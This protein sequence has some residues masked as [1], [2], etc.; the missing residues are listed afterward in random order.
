MIARGGHLGVT[1]DH[2]VFEPHALNLNTQEN[3]IAI[4]FTKL[5]G[6]RKHKR[7]AA[8]LLTATTTAGI[9]FEFVCWKRDAVIEAV[10]QQYPQIAASE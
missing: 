4:P 5:T 7:I 3:R 6:L 2:L 8:V 10:R 1:Q 9:D